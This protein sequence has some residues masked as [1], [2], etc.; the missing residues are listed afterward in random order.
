MSSKKDHERPVEEDPD[1]EQD[2]D[3]SQRRRHKSAVRGEMD[4]FQEWMRERRDRGRK[5]RRKDDQRGR[6]D[7][8]DV[9]A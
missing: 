9:D 7:R 8:W 4:E 2:L 3:L 1:V 5:P 6:R